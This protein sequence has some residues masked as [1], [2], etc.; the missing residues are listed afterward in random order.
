MTEQ[1]AI[2]KYENYNR[3]KAYGQSP[4]VVNTFVQLLGKTAPHYIQSALLAVQAND[5]LMGCSPRSIF[6]A[7]LRAAT[8]GLTC[9]PSLGHAYIVPYK[10]KNGEYEANFQPGWRGIQSMAL[11]TGKYVYINISPIYKGEDVIEDRI[12]GDLRIGYT[13][14]VSKTQKGLIASF[15]LTSG[16]KKSIYMTNEELEE[17][18]RTYSKSYNRSDSIWKTNKKMAYHKTILLKLIRTYGYLNPNET[19]LLDEEEDGGIVDVDLPRED[20]VTAIESEPMSTSEI[21][22]LFGFGDDEDVADG[23]FVEEPDFA[24]EPE[25]ENK[26]TI[27]TPLLEE[28]YGVKTSEG[29]LYGEMTEAGLERMLS[30]MWKQLRQNHLEPDERVEI[31]R[32][33][34]AA[35][36]VLAAKRTGE[37]N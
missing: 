18:G 27:P 3:I 7:A 13:T 16:F 4:E 5:T 30:H 35:Q 25:P 23:D 32:K 2:A 22:E 26:P 24:P 6:R 28:A 10:N 8:L 21:N 37:I 14:T 11:R 33:I 1:T 31:E 36:V 34:K 9:D 17:H 15:K 12:T 19:A 20:A 29:K